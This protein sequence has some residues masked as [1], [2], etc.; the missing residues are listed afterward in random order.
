M[1][2]RLITKRLLWALFKMSVFILLLLEVR[3]FSPIFAVRG[4][5]QGLWRFTHAS[6]DPPLQ[7]WTSM[8]FNLSNIST[9]ILSQFISHCLGFSTLVL[10]PTKISDLVNYD[11]LYQPVCLFILR[12]S[13]LPWGLSS[14]VNLSGV[15][16]FQFLQVFPCY[17]VGNDKFQLLTC[18]KDWKLE[19]STVLTIVN[20]V[21]LKNKRI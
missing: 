14:F 17:V 1:R 16:D 19:I 13:G 10:V 11:S 6:V 8:S 2:A 20:K 9:L 18:W 15:V 4:T 5:W 21:P 3:Y 12:G 7:D